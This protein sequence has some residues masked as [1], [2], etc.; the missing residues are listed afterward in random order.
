MNTSPSPTR[1]SGKEK[2][3]RYIKDSV[4]VFLTLKGKNEMKY[5]TQNSLDHSTVGYVPDALRAPDDDE[6]HMRA[7]K[8]CSGLP[9]WSSD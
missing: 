4:G 9:W 1:N 5:H 7:I 2:G 3:M 8:M 6:D